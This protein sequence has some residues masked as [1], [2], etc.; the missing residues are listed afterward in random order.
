[1]LTYTRTNC[2]FAQ[3]T[4]HAGRGK[5]PHGTFVIDAKSALRLET[6][7]ESI[8]QAIKESKV[9]HCPLL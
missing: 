4:F 3:N 1:M 7:L 6:L 5:E 2:I 8:G 9:A